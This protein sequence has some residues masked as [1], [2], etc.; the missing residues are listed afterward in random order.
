MMISIRGCLPLLALLAFGAAA[1]ATGQAVPTGSRFDVAVGRSSLGASLDC[2]VCNDVEIDRRGG[3][4][5]ALGITRPLNSR[6]GIRFDG[7]VAK[8][9]GEYLGTVTVGLQY[10]A[11]PLAG[12]FVHGG[13]GAYHRTSSNGCLGLAES[14]AA[15]D[16]DCGWDAEMATALAL[17]VGAYLPVVGALVPTIRLDWQRSLINGFGSSDFPL[18]YNQVTVLVGLAFGI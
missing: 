15:S 7:N 1:T 11:L 12:V 17:G 14:G 18:H 10:L 13:L 16:S 2:S 8:L 4:A 3:W 5:L 6:L 9:P